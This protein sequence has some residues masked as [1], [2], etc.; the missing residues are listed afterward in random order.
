MEKLEG[1]VSDWMREQEALA[2]ENPLMPVHD[3]RIQLRQN[4][5]DANPA[6]VHEIE[7]REV[8]RIWQDEGVEDAI[9]S[10]RVLLFRCGD[11]S[12]FSLSV[13]DSGIA[14]E[15]IFAYAPEAV[16]SELEDSIVRVS[17]S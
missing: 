5:G 1:S 16:V 11:G 6:P 3:S 14:G 10:D 9:Q 17:I 7:I 4:T 12:R 2:L 15:L 13:D 8:R